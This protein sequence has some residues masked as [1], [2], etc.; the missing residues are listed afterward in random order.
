MFDLLLKRVLLVLFV[1]SSVFPVFADYS[2][3]TKKPILIQDEIAK[4]NLD[5]QKQNITAQ[6]KHD[7]YAKLGRLFHLEG[8]IEA[9][10]KAWENA[11]FAVPERRDDIALLENASC[12]MAMGEWD[13]AEASVKIVLLTAKTDSQNFLKA[14][15][16]N[17]QIEAFRNKNFTILDAYT[18]DPAF[19]SVRPALYYTLWKITGNNEYK[20]KL[21]TEYP[22]SPETRTLFVDSGA[23]EVVS[24]SPAAY[25]MLFPGRQDARIAELAASPA[26]VPEGKL[27]GASP[28]SLQT[29][30]FNSEQ[31]AAVQA[32]KLTSAG[33][34]ANIIR[35]TVSGS[36]YWAVAVP[37]G[38]N[39]NSTIQKLKQ[40]GFE[41]FPVF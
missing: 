8:N 32:G 34:T 17:A 30:L 7:A 27:E 26:T 5:L 16:L 39:V 37:A 12:L 15:Y 11:A 6:D 33:F 10:A 13:K 29:G 20:A 9:S 19:V 21:I 41:S 28:V 25:W 3:G 36:T 23:V 22:E 35:R 40:A 31:N 18:D 14:K 4:I 1:G 38:T 2:G 24:A